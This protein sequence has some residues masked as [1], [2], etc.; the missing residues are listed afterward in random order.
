MMTMWRQFAA[1]LLLGSMGCEQA[2]TQAPDGDVTYYH[3]IK[4]LIDAYCVRCHSVGGVAPF[5]MTTF[6]EVKEVGAL[7]PPTLTTRQMPPFL[8]APAVRGLDYDTSL[9]NE[10]IVLINSWIADGMTAGDPQD[11]GANIPLV[12]RALSRVDLTLEMPIEYTPTEIPD[13]Y[14]CFPIDWP[15][16]EESFITGLNLR[17]GNEAVAHHAIA[18]LIDPDYIDLVVAADGLD[19]KPGYSCFG[20][21]TPPNT[22]AFPTKIIAGWA[23]GESGMDFPTGTGVRVR[24]GS[25]IVLQMHYSIL[26]EGSQPDLSALDFKI[27]ST[28]AKDAGNLPWLNLEW[29]S[30]PQSMLIPAGNAD[31]VH[32]YI[33]DPTQAALLGEFVPGLDPREGILLHSVLPH[34]HKLGKAIWLE[35]ERVDGTRE[36]IIQIDRWD[37]DWQ[38]YYTFQEP[39]L[40]KPGDKLRIHCE[41]D[42]SAKNQ[43]VIDGV[44]RPVSDV[45]WG[46]GTYDEMC[47]ASIYVSGV[48]QGS[49]TCAAVGSVSAEEGMFRVTFDAPDSIRNA[50]NLE[51]E[52]RG[53]VYG[54]LYRAEDVKLTGPVAGAQPVASFQFDD[55]DLRQG[56]AGPFD[57]SSIPAGEYQFLGFMD[58][59]GNADLNAPEPDL[60][61]PVMIPSRASSLE[62]AVQPVTVQFPLLLPNL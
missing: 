43:P 27:D 28:I 24:P 57:M 14:R 5:S 9:S 61:D 38:G 42:N 12:L 16:T 44:P 33:A 21:A 8:A 52:L 11:E 1:L 40:M 18:Y 3:N 36:R 32:E 26:A 13:E 50:S 29:T 35:I 62:C 56:P 48:A 10:Q 60:N 6:A 39:A 20:G 47:A 23:P 54:S 45:T 58:T 2:Q 17:P 53:R 19:G 4:P 49:A 22:G 51:G 7:I 41:W 37:F 31:V 59:D 15:S 25:K 55:I 46:E 30:T 34:L